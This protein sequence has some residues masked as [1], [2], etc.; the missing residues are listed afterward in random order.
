MSATS[1]RAMRRLTAVSAAAFLL[2][3]AIPQAMTNGPPALGTVG[4]SGAAHVSGSFGSAL[5]ATAPASLPGSVAIDTRTNTIYVANGY[6]PDSPLDGGHTV[7]VIDGRRCQAANVSRCG[8]PWPTVPVGN[9]PSTVAV[10][11]TT[12]TIYVTNNGDGTV[13]VVNGRTCNAEVHSGCGQSPPAVTVGTPDTATNGIFVDTAHHTVYVGNFNTT[14]LAMIDTRNC[15]AADLHGCAGQHPPTVTVG[16]GP[17]DVDVN[18]QTHTAYVALLVAV[19]AFDTDTCNAS[20]QSGCGH[21]G[22]VAPDLSG[23]GDF[24]DC[25]PFSA[26][27]DEANNTVYASTGSANRVLVID[28]RR[29]NARDLIGCAS[30]PAATVAIGPPGIEGTI[31][32]AVD[33]PAHTVYVTNHKDDDLSV[34][35]AATC[36]GRHLSACAALVPPTIHTGTNPLAI[37][38]NEKTQTVYVGNEYDNNVAVIAA[39]DCDATETRGCRHPAPTVAAGPGPNAIAIDENVHTAYVTNGAGVDQ[40]GPRAGSTVSM[41]DTKRCNARHLVG[42]AQTP[43]IVTVGALPTA[44]AIDTARHTVY[45]ADRGSGTS[46]SVSLINDRTCNATTHTGCANAPEF[47]VTNGNPTA[48][49]LN[50]TTGTVYVAVAPPSGP[51][52]IDVYNAATCNAANTTGCSQSPA[53]VTVGPAGRQ[54]PG[55]A[56]NRMTNTI[57]ATNVGSIADGLAGDQLYVINGNRCDAAN[58]SGC[59]TPPA[60]TTVGLPTF[61]AIGQAASPE[62]VAV[63]EATNTVYVADLENGEGYGAVSVV[64]GATCNGTT[65]SGCTDQAAPTVAAGFGTFGVAIDSKANRIYATGIQDTSVSI[66]NG[67][68]CNATTTTGCNQTPPKAAIG[69]FPSALAVDHTEHTVYIIDN[70]G[71]DVSIIRT[72]N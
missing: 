29:C 47:A 64:N 45:V 16:E 12:N 65:T 42:C 50:T 6:D 44:L 71:T 52:L 57:Y 46:G 68:I 31:W 69:D 59:A 15:N 32:V 2:S 48:I 19:A 61:K 41:I 53:I 34:I 40:R 8:G 72:P 21:T 3:L 25:G 17:G 4:V 14:E 9:L 55:M 7:T 26:K 70:R 67:A 28:G 36:N 18:T 35:D 1:N 30:Y 51:S 62:G 63:N 11:E 43:P 49:A 38:A 22:I 27:V 20:T 60:T 66:I 23:C 33:A 56:V 10:D 24:G 58:A 5:R 13:S 39:A 37:A 54:I